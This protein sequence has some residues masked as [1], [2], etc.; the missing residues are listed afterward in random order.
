MVG[1]SELRRKDL[2]L[3][4]AQK[5][6]FSKGYEA[7][8]VGDLIAEAGV[9]K[10]G[11]Y[12]YYKSKEQLLDDL[13]EVHTQKHIKAWRVICKDQSIGAVEKLKKVFGDSAMVKAKDYK[14]VLTMVRVYYQSGNLLLRDKLERYSA[15]VMTRE[16]SSL[17]YEGIVEGVFDTAFPDSVFKTLVFL[18]HSVQEEIVKLFLEYDETQDKAVVDQIK[19]IYAQTDDYFCRILG[20]KD[21]AFRLIDDELIESFMEKFES[22]KL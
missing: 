16:L 2:I 7:T 9:S 12:H 5:L 6:F 10:G 1:T 17:I 21:K 15:E 20:I 19:N 4:A 11:F 18:F 13:V 14:F 8:S 22:K 3:Q